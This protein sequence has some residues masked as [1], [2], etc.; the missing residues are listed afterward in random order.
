MPRLPP[1]STLPVLEAA[2]R[3][4]SISL[5][6][7]ELHVTHGAVSHQIKS[8]EEFLGVKMFVRS[9]R[10][11]VPTIEGELLAEAT[12]E[13][14]EK[15]AGTIESLKPAAR[16]HTLVISV[17]PSFASRWLMPRLGNFL[18]SHPS[19]QISVEA[20][21]QLANFRSDGVDV[22]IRYGA[23]PWP[24]LHSTRLAGDSYIVV[25]SPKFRKGRLPKRPEQMIGLPLFC[26]EPG[27]WK[28]WF[29][30]A[31]VDFE[32]HSQAIEYND[33][34]LYLQ[35]AVAREGI[36]LTRR[37]IAASDLAEG[38]LLRLFDHQLP[39]DRS[40]HLVCL[41]QCANWPKIMAFR[42]WIVKQIDWD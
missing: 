17:L 4:K 39:S 20:S 33:A 15:I 3:L 32:P 8:L 27:L 6:A 37:S 14:L 29:A 26:S 19:M 42:E 38:R 25:C 36:V 2:A 9:G 23:G 35:Q 1:L 21:Q 10:G 40:Y 30:L 18:E 7:D 41:P 31:G 34:A 24:G 12:R 5:A 28:Q 11:V 16:E 13:A 22:A